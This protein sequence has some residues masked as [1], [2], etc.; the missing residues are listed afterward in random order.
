[1]VAN[2][3]RW[4]VSITKGS[5][6]GART[7]SPG[8]NVRTLEVLVGT[9]LPEGSDGY[10]NDA[11]VEFLQLPVAQLKSIEIPPYLKAIV[12]SLY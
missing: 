1:M 3:E 9:G 2:P 6:V 10:K 4:A 11:R 7:R 8:N 5:H 12:L